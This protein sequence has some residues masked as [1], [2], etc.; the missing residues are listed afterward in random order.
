[1]T[2]PEQMATQLHSVCPRCGSPVRRLAAG[3]VCARC[4]FESALSEPVPDWRSSVQGEHRGRLGRYELLEEIAHG[5]MGVVYRARDRTLNRV[6]ALKL[7]LGGQFA[8]QREIKRFQ[9]EAEA[10]AKLDHPNIVPIYE[11]GEQDG[12][13][14]FSMKFMEGGTLTEGLDGSDTVLDNRKAA[15]LLAKIAR[16]VHHA[17]QRAVLHRDLKPGNILLDAHGEPHVSDFG[18]AKCLDAKDGSTATGAMVGSP[19]FMSPEQAAGHADQLTTASDIYS[20][21]ALLYQ[22]LTGRPPFEAATALATLEKVVHQEP[23]PPRALQSAVDQDLETI[24]LKCLEKKSEHRYGS[25]EALAED[26]ERWLRREPILARPIGAVGRLSKWTQRNPGT[27]TLILISSLAIVAF[28]VGQTFMSLRLSRANVKVQTANVGLSRSLHEMRW[29]QADEAVQ[30][31]ERGEAI[32]RFSQFLRENPNDPTAAARLLSLL[33]SC[34][35]PMLLLPPLAHESTVVALDFN[36]AGDRLATASSGGVARL[37]NV[38]SGKMELELKH[39][40]Q[41]THCVLCGEGD[42]RLLTLTSEPKARLWDLRTQ[43]LILETDWTP[44]D[45]VQGTR[46]VAPTRDRGRIALRLNSNVVG[47]F[48]VNTGAWLKPL[49][50]MPAEISLYAISADGNLVASASPSQVQLFKVGSDQPLFAPVALTGPPLD[51]QFSDDAHWLACLTDNG[52]WVMNTATGARE[53]ELKTKASRIAFL[54]RSERIITIPPDPAT[55]LGLIDP[56]FGLIDP[57][58]VQEYGSPFGHPDFDARW[59]GPLLFSF[60]N[61]GPVYPSRLALLDPVNGRFQTELFIHDGPISAQK[62]SPDGRSVATASQ[63]RTVRLWSVDMR[64]AEPLTLPIG[65]GVHEAQWSPSGDRILSS[66]ARPHSEVRL[67][68]S[69]SGARLGLLPNLE[70]DIFW[71]QWAPDG[72]RFATASVHATA[73]IWDARTSQPL[74][75]PLHHDDALVHCAFSPNGELLA[76]ASDDNTVRLWDGHNGKAIGEPLV[77]P[78]APLKISFSSDGRRLATGC[79]DGSICVW[80]IPDGRLLVGPLHHGGI[81]WV[82]AFSPDDH[83]LVSASSD[84]T[85]QLWDAATGQPALPPF[86]HE[87][88]VLWASF[89]PDGHAIATST[90]SGT[91]RF[92]DSATGHLLWEPVRQPGKIWY[93]KWSA[94]GRFLVTTST[95]GSARIWDAF[96]GHLVAE[97]FSHPAELRR[98]EFSPDGQRLLTAGYDGTIKIWNLALLR[99]PLPVPDWLP[100]LAESLVGKR[101][102]PKDSVESVPS[103][104]FQL[105][106]TRIEQWGTNDY[107]GRW[108]RWFLHERFERPVKAFHP[109]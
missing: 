5:G 48:D 11:V 8:G 63:D 29:R 41:L 77:H 31:D 75:P 27:A 36:Q 104:S 53:P 18:L 96:T 46:N 19:S 64:P 97:P 60:K 22:L 32:A 67:W 107:Y 83:W 70:N 74:S 30:A 39:P 7:M 57:H 61:T 9:A 65:S 17:H 85:A 45:K 2:A 87:G 51:L 92:W 42:V 1:M 66:S 28:L 14:F 16:A 78:H 68:D 37:W 108:A 80:S 76:T 109:Q 88:P 50:T 99:P 56:H 81:C 6:V 10:A 15:L 101:I 24:C 79:I 73:R 71:A 59:H 13:P 94:D 95:D 103:D 23:R 44:W 98:A 12:R 26:L 58:S 91:T 90:E 38:R 100:G 43:H 54:G 34:N 89:S 102:G 106:K 93:V 55:S 82:A 3:G 52:I 49:L 20:L 69:Q 105:A 4:L 33:S 62:F 84:S 72:K 21:G 40:A 47:V 25:A 86:R 35:F